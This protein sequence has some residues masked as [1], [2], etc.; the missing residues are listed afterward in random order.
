MEERPPFLLMSKSRLCALSPISR[1]TRVEERPSLLRV[2]SRKKEV[3]VGHPSTCVDFE[4]IG[5]GGGVVPLSS[6]RNR[7]ERSWKTSSLSIL[8]VMGLVGERVI[9][10]VNR[11]GPPP[12]CQI[13]DWEAEKGSY[14]LFVEIE[15]NGGGARPFS[16]KEY[17]WRRDPRRNRW[18]WRWQRGRRS[19]CHVEENGEGLSL[20]DPGKHRDRNTSYTIE[21]HKDNCFD[22]K[23]IWNTN[24]SR[25]TT[26]GKERME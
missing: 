21:T 19:G 11:G 7:G 10:E 8:S 17:A 18:E 26:R 3:E 2:K 4:G 14:L 20:L 15:G 24:K 22:G 1:G 9:F 25:Y 23:S 12:S 6:C 13:E 5:D 16:L